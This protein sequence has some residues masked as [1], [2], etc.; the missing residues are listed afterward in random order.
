MGVK[1]SY[2]AQ[3]RPGAYSSD[4][5]FLVPSKENTLT[6]GAT[7][8]LTGIVGGETSVETKQLIHV[9][10]KRPT[11]FNVAVIMALGPHWTGEGAVALQ[12]IYVIGVGQTR[13]SFVR[14]LIVATPLDNSAAINDVFQLPATAMQ[15]SCR[16]IT[17]ALVN[18]GPHAATITALAAPVYA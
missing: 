8:T 17:S 5:E 15:V 11:S 3:T 9:S 16:L 13:A 14:L 1:D 2:E 6:W 4:S 10:R 18:P 12:V 7:E